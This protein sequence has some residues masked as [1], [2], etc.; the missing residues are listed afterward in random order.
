MGRVERFGKRRQQYLRRGWGGV[1]RVQGQEACEAALE[2]R[3]VDWKS[4]R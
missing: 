2:G 4:D 1:G 3:G